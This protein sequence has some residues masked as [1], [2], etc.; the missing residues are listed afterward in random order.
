MAINRRG[1]RRVSF[2]LLR[3]LNVPLKRKIWTNV[4]LHVIATENPS[5]E[6]TGPDG[7]VELRGSRKRYRKRCNNLTKPVICLSRELRRTDVKNRKCTTY[8][9]IGIASRYFRT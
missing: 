8:V 5:P 2:F 1:F 6:P 7:R 4:A 3:D 9:V